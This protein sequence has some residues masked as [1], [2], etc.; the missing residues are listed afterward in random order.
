SLVAVLPVCYWRENIRDMHKKGSRSGFRQYL[1]G[2]HA[3]ACIR[4]IWVNNKCNRGYYAN[5]Q[6]GPMMG[7]TMA[8]LRETAG[9]WEAWVADD[10][11]PW[12]NRSDGAQIGFRLG[13]RGA[14]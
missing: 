13:R 7:T 14:R 2:F 5:H 6:T 8:R 10:A 12:A 4:Y 3:I 1:C 9:L 11:T